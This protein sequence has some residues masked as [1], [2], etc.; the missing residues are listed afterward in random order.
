[1]YYILIGLSISII[2]EDLN[3]EEL[4]I[5]FLVDE[6]T[7]EELAILETHLEKDD[8]SRRF[9]NQVNKLCRRRQYVKNFSR[10]RQMRVGIKSH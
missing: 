8:E 9:F 4:A 2:E 6:I 5:R 1:L 10:S 3:F 7:E